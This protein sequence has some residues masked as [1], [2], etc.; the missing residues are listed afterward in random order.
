MTTVIA[1][2]VLYY[3]G[4]GSV[5]GFALTLLIGVILSFLTAVFVT[6][7]FLDRIVRMGATKPGMFGVK[8]VKGQ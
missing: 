4:T 3:F 7:F 6:K 8:E 5:K 2:V 1:A